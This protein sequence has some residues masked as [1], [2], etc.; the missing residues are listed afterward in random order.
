[1]VPPAPKCVKRDMFLVYDLSYQHVQLKPY[2]M[3]LAYAQALQYWAEEANPPAPSKP[4][5]L[6]MSVCKLRW[7]MGKHTTFHDCN[8]FE[9]L[10]NALP[11][12]M[13]KDAQPSPTGSS[14]A[15]DLTI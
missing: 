15:E 7:H 8:V 2:Q 12:A 11:R 4:C 3:T 14:P 6:A 5:L 9:G 10:A 1:M 13:V